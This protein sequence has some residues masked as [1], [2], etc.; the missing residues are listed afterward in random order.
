ML[1]ILVEDMKSSIFSQYLRDCL[2][3]SDDLHLFYGLFYGWNDES[4]ELD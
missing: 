3:L 4:A 2:P 1:T